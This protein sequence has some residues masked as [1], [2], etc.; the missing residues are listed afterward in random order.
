MRK[1]KRIMT[2]RSKETEITSIWPKRIES[3]LNSIGFDFESNW[4]DFCLIL[5]PFF[6]KE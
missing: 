1:I 5:L 3:D 4:I 6:M 2:K